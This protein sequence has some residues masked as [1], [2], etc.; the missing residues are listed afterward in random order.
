MHRCG[1]LSATYDNTMT[2]SQA[3]RDGEIATSA[4]R[5]RNH[6]SPW[7]RVR[8]GHGGAGGAVPTAAPAP[9]ASNRWLGRRPS[10]WLGLHGTAALPEM[11][12]GRGRRSFGRSVADGGATC[13]PGVRDRSR[14]I[15]HVHRKTP[16]WTA[17]APAFS[18]LRIPKKPSSLVERH[19]RVHGERLDILN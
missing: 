16:V 12:D 6:N 19:N 3:R 9:A 8:A 10:A 4:T 11:S 17:R 18:L 13:S 1:F 15:C 7:E 14:L 5:W 2:S